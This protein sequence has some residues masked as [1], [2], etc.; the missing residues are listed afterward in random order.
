MTFDSYFKTIA[1]HCSMVVAH[2]VERLLPIPE[3][4]S[5][6]PVIGKKL[7]P[8][9]VYCQL[10]WKDEKR[11]KEAENGLFK[12]YSARLTESEYN[13]GK[14]ACGYSTLDKVDNFGHSQQITNWF[15]YVLT[16]QD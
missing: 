4:C 10:Y 14:Q 7:Y 15:N 11:E 8:T 6:N 5:S 9:F 12:K 16:G 13:S 3:I 1:L 2:L